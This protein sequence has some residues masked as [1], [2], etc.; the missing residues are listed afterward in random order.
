MSVS[1]QPILKQD[2]PQREESLRFQRKKKADEEFEENLKKFNKEQEEFEAALNKFNSDI[3]NIESTTRTETETGSIDTVARDAELAAV[4]TQIQSEIKAI[5]DERDQK[6]ADRNNKDL[7]NGIGRS[8]RQV[9]RN[10]IWNNYKSQLNKVSRDGKIETEQIKLKHSGL[11]AWAQQSARREW[12]P[13]QFPNTSLVALAKKKVDAKKAENESSRLSSIKNAQSNALKAAEKFSVDPAGFNAT[14]QNFGATNLREF[15]QAELKRREEIKPLPPSRIA[16]VNGVSLTQSE[17]R[18]TRVGVKFNVLT[19]STPIKESAD[20]IAINNFLNRL[21]TTNRVSGSVIEGVLADKGVKLTQ[22]GND[23][24]K[25]LTEVRGTSVF[26]R[27]GTIT[28]KKT[29]ESFNTITGVGSNRIAQG[30]GITVPI[31]TPVKAPEPVEQTVKIS[32]GK[33]ISNVAVVQPKFTDAKVLPLESIFAFVDEKSRA[34]QKISDA[35]PNDPIAAAMAAGSSFQAGI[36]NS[37]TLAGDLIDKHLLKKDPILKKPVF[38]GITFYDKGIERAVQDIKFDSQESFV[39]SVPSINPT[40]EGNVFQKFVQGAENQF[41]KQT[42]AQNFGQ[43]LVLA[44]VVA[45]DIAT[46]LQGGSSILRNVGKVA[47]KIKPKAPSTPSFVITKTGKIFPTNQK[48]LTQAQINQPVAATSKPSSFSRAIIELGHGQPQKPRNLVK[49]VELDS[50]FKPATRVNEIPISNAEFRTNFDRTPIKLGTGAVKQP[51]APVKPFKPTPVKPDSSFKPATRV[52]EIPISNSDVSAAFSSTPIRLG[53]GAVKQPKAP[54]KPFK[55]TPVKPDSSFKPATRVN[56]IPISNSDVSAAFSSTPIRLGTGA[57]KQPKAPVKPFKPTPVKPDSSFKPA[58]R[59]NEIPISNS[60]VSAAFSKK[61]VKLGFGNVSELKLT[62]KGTPLNIKKMFGSR[63]GERS[64]IN[65]KKFEEPKISDDTISVKTTGGQSLLL[66]PQKTIQKTKTKKVLPKTIKK[67][68]VVNSQPISRDFTRVESVGFVPKTSSKQPVKTISITKQKPKKK[69]P[70]KTNQS[71]GSAVT[72]VENVTT[73]TP[74]SLSILTQKNQLVVGAVPR[75]TTKTNTK[76]KTSTASK[77]KISQSPKLTQSSRQT[78]IVRTIPITRSITKTKTQVK[79]SRALVPRPIKP[80]RS[81]TS[82]PTRVPRTTA[83][84]VTV[85]VN[86]RR[87]IIG[88]TA[89]LPKPR[90]RQTTQKKPTKP[91]KQREFIGNTQLT[92]IEGVFK[93]RDIVIGRKKVEKIVS[94]E[95]SK[96]NKSGKTKKTKVSKKSKVRII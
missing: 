56:E 17:N 83:I 42:P 48:P 65:P 7:A 11:P 81:I 9:N 72:V 14:I 93:D 16:T 88:V 67:L 61:T 2:I 25:S 41:R 10:V 94:K 78:E 66:A 64:A 92:K 51:K 46:G 45:L 69:Q 6:I 43:T 49:N 34:N 96:L 31:A 50:S 90:R 79:Q 70:T 28:D 85:P 36:L 39:S 35:N 22:R 73:V 74:K 86:P 59:V 62:G 52:N 18:P 29:G 44:P 68:D 12:D 71:T 75:Q 8:Q 84:P 58:T 95:F 37:V 47:T 5:T 63:G 53:T 87:P 30:L 60:D 33:V 57:V 24:I 23:L 76:L 27:T 19:T 89:P 55:P 32:K 21:K 80:V 4:N 82:R 15:S 1:T 13:V 54:V 3:E 20:I 38:T 91:K 77:T 26:T 40:K